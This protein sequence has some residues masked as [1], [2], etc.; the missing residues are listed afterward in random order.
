MADALIGFDEV[1]RQDLIAALVQREL[2][3]Q[4]VLAPTV[5]NVS[6]YAVKGAKSITFP[7]AG[8]FAVHDKLQNT[9]V[10][11]QTLTYS[12]DTLSL[13]LHKVIQWVIEKSASVQTPVDVE[14]DAISRA[15]RAM[16]K[17]LDSDIHAALILASSSSPDHI[18][19]FAGSA[20]AIADIVDANK[21][22]DIQDV[23]QDGRVLAI[24][25]TDKAA[26]LKIASFVDASQWGNNQPIAKGVIGEVYGCKVVMSTVVTTSRPILYHN[27]AVAW[28]LQMGPEFDQQKDL[29]N[30]GQRYS[31]DQMYGVKVMQGGIMQVRMGSAS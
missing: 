16:A 24:S 13:N 20:I 22:L 21:L 27:E 17:Q 2:I 6:K 4:S 15:T 18:V 28:G 11:A 9:E 8:H 1:Q 10:E 23:P 29:K 7:Y 26:L 31:L 3:A 14:L 12:G 25:P 30:L 5:M 19:A